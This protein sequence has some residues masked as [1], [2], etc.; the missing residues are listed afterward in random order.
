LTA[1]EIHEMR[2]RN[3][4]ARIAVP[5]ALLASVCAGWKWDAFPH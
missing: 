5:A 4:F 2:L 3:M 1:K